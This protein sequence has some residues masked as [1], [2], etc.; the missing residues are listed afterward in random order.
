MISI[1]K[2]ITQKNDPLQKIEIKRLFK[3]IV[4]PPDHLKSQIE[5][6][7]TVMSIDNNRYRHLKTQ[8]P[9]VCCG[10]FNPP[11]RLTDNFASISHFILDIDHIK[12][13]GLDIDQL[14][15]KFTE[16][17]RVELV[18]ESPG[19]DGLKV[20]FKLEEKCYDHAKYSIFYKI[21]AHAFSR[22]Y[23]LDQV[24][25]YRTSDVTRACFMSFDSDAHYKPDPALVEMQR[26]VNFEDETQVNEAKH[27]IREV[28][29]DHKPKPEPKKEID[30]DIFSE[31]K[32]KLN[33]GL[34]KK[35]EKKIYVP[36]ELNRIIEKVKEKVAEH[37]IE[38]TEIINIHYGKK[39]RFKL[40]EYQAEINVFYGKKGFSVVKS[41][42]RGTSEE[43]N[44]IVY[45]LLC[46]LFFN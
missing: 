36:E 42:R 6:L 45:T 28:E 15:N 46:E 2:S 34:R 9:Y 38:T 21:F 44:E 39:F 5:Q 13:K 11:Y 40:Q 37:K 43:L 7:R 12:S 19:K 14:K 24:I 26:F 18:F 17:K 31:I 10:I 35:A 41:P 25:D 20:F 4:N 23:N 1:G 22:Q 29:R 27:I 16:D 8:L 30:P 3:A 33:P 32:M